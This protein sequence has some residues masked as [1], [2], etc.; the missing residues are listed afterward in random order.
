MMTDDPLPPR[1]WKWVGANFL[2]DKKPNRDFIVW[3]FTQ[4]Q[5]LFK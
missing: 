4:P 2:K 5:N 1:R 3:N